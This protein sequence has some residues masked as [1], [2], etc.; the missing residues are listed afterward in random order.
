MS[1]EKIYNTAQQLMAGRLG[2]KHSE[3]ETPEIPSY[4]L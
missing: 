4:G 2:Y 3:A 1:K